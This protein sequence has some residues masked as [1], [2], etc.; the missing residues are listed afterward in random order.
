MHI[1]ANATSA[2]PP[3][4]AATERSLRRAAGEP[5]EAKIA[6]V[7]SEAISAIAVPQCHTTEVG[8]FASFTVAAPKKTWK[9]KSAPTA[10]AAGRT[11]G[12]AGLR[13]FNASAMVHSTSA[14][15]ASAVKRW[16]HSHT[17]P[18]SK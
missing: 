1:V 7:A 3:V 5:C 13:R 17:T 11:N 14:Q 16:V 10:A 18:P 12:A 6:S 2:A 9:R 15:S 8:E 4:N